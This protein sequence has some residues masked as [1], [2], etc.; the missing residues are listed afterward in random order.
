LY[1]YIGRRVTTNEEKTRNKNENAASG[2]RAAKAL[3][4]NRVFFFFFELFFAVVALF[5]APVRGA[6]AAARAETDHR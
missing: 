2:A 4:L 3:E 6:R 5:Q 1:F